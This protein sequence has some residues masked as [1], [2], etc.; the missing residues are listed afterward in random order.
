MR[1]EITAFTR[2]GREL[3]ERIA[4]LL[5]GRGDNAT[6]SSGV[7]VVQWT[8]QAFA[9]ADAL[10]FVGAAGI[11]VRA[12]AG[13]VVSKLSDP[14]V[15]VVDEKGRYCI[16][17]LSGHVGGANALALT[18]AEL[19]G[20]QAVITTATD[21]NGVFAVDSWAAQR[22]LT[23]A[24]PGRIKN[25]S[26]KLLEGGII[27]IRSDFPIA[28]ELP[29][30]AELTE[31][32]CD[33]CITARS[34]CGQDALRLVPAVAVLGVGCR[35]E[36]TLEAIE[37]A[38]S[39]MLEES[40]MD[41]A[42]VCAVAT[43]TLK[44]KEPA[45][46]EFCQKHGLKLLAFTAEQLNRLKGSFAGS[47]FVRQTTGTDSVCERSAVAASGNKVFFGK[48]ATNGVTMAVSLSNYTVN[49]EEKI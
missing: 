26:A 30:G 36:I 23:I 28:G 8:Q 19:L 37:T 44:E 46:M 14:A 40:G 38:Y 42:A 39:R 31:G 43:I 25:V 12:V 35:K 13:H 2:T 10:V 47:E 33:L 7:P 34:D 20:A 11:A 9:G 24:N 41:A 5:R 17:L 29:R 1:V 22:G 6:F 49:F 45:L 48:L 32:D 18:L 4:G 3:G 16:P 15:V 27:R 21:L